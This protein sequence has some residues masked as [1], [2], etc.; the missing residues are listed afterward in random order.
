MTKPNGLENQDM[1][2]ADKVTYWL[3]LGGIFIASV[4]LGIC[5]VGMIMFR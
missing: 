1:S 3:S 2:E 5:I 4:V